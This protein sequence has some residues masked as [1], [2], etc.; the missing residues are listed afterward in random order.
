MY[1]NIILFLVVK[2]IT[3]YI[4]FSFKIEEDKS[5][6]S[7]IETIMKTPLK[8]DI[9]IGNPLQTVP[10]YIKF[11]E[12]YSYLS[13]TGIS[14]HIYNEKQSSTYK[15]KEEE[16]SYYDTSFNYGIPSIEKF[17]FETNE[18]KIIESKNFTFILA[19]NESKKIDINSGV[20]GLKL[21]QFTYD[22]DGYFLHE[23]KMKG[24]TDSYSWT[25]KLEKEDEGNIYLGEYPHEY[26]TS[27]YNLIYYKTTRVGNDAGKPTWSII[28]DRIYFGE[29]NKIDEDNQ[30]ILNYESGVIIGTTTF[31]KEVSD[32]FFN[33]YNDKECI[34]QR[35]KI[36]NYYFY[37]CDTSIDISKFPKLI[38]FNRDINMNFELNYKDL[39]VKKNGKYHFLIVFYVM[40]TFRWTFGRPFLKKYQI[41]FDHDRKL[42]G[43]YTQIG[44][45]FPWNTFIIIFL[46]LIIIALVYYII[47]YFKNKPK[48]IKANE[49][50]EDLDYLINN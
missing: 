39:F 43:T 32:K 44:R 25:I 23:L 20:L 6:V 9:K 19:T 30:A 42:I 38:F 3:S 33:K 14:K 16:K 8:F 31:I 50:L 4:K 45:S 27:N 46:G 15:K 24:L 18:K 41:V 35:T 11:D 2:T 47:I 28:F 36:T 1:L 37:I 17:Q 26:D 13:G 12:S 21:A 5:A 49:L 7:Y 22:K 40:N 48:R 10:I 29:D 34:F